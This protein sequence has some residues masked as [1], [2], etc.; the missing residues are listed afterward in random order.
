MPKVVLFDIDNTLLYT[1]GAG[2]VAMTR[3]FEEIYGVPNGF[4]GVEFSGRTDLFIL[5]GGL[6]LHGVEG[7][8]SD[9]LD[10]FTARYYALLPESIEKCRAD[11]RVMPGFPQLVQALTASGAT[12]GLATGNFSRAGYIK[13]ESY[14]LDGLFAGGGFGET[15][16]DR[17]DIVAEAIRVV[18]NGASPSDVIVVGDTPHDITAASANGAKGVGVATGRDPVDVLR[19]SGA[20]EVFPDFADWEAAAQ[21]LLGL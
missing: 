4:S 3:A 5:E 19:E 14:G 21:R 15:S 6:R 9:H 11:G 13:L 7:T 10:A 12:V 20:V 18:A 8:A 1:G 16:L 2:S 17:A